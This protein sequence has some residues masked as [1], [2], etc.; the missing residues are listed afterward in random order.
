MATLN[1]QIVVLDTH[2]I[3]SIAIA[4][5]SSYTDNPPITVSPMLRIE[6]PGYPPVTTP[7]NVAG[8]HILTSDMMGITAAG[9]RTALPDGVYTFT[10]SEGTASSKV[11]YMRVDELLEKYYT[12]FMDL[13][14]MECNQAIKTQAKVDL[15]TIYLLIQGSIAAASNCAILTA[16]ELYGQANKMLAR[17]AKHNCGCTGSNYIINYK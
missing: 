16:N 4:D 14:M 11:S 15:S 10:Y 7:F 3:H 9:I 13:D 6:P 8:Y 2:D 1:I 12:V 5:A 17:M